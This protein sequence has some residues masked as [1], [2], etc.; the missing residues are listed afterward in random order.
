M[1]SCGIP[2]V[3]LVGKLFFLGAWAGFSFQSFLLLPPKTKGGRSKKD[4]HCNLWR[5]QPKHSPAIP[6]SFNIAPLW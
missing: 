1:V 2:W 4:F 3:N 5:E 6:T